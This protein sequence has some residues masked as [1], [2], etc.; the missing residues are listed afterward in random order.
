[1]F[2][3]E[4][5]LLDRIANSSSDLTI[6]A[7][8]ALVFAVVGGVIAYL[9]HK[10]WFRYW[11]TDSEYDDKL[12]E[13]AHTSMLGFAAFVLALL[14]SNGLSTLSETDKEVRAEATT[15]YRL[16]RELEAIGPEAGAA[17]EALAAYVK[18]V[19][20]DEWRRL[21]TLPVA[22]SPLAQ[23]NLDDLWI[24]LRALQAKEAEAAPSRSD[25]RADLSRHL[26]Q[27]ET[28]RS[29]RL[30]SATM[31]I[32]DD[33]WVILLLF[34]IAA[35]ILSGRRTAKRFGIQVNIMHMS[36]IGLAVGMVVVLDNP[37]RGE[38]SI[39]PEII[40]QAW[41][42]SPTRAEEGLSALQSPAAPVPGEAKAAPLPTK[43]AG[44]SRTG[45]NYGNR[46]R[47]SP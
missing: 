17:K 16:G 35:S 3:V 44:L 6:L 30:S 38:T 2:G 36:A 26:S 10:F 18:N 4:Q 33:F 21:A 47:R 28:L 14:I 39:G 22:L 1:M 12:A 46:G 37:F 29:G 40:E 42:P 20:Q 34:V 11:P 45:T 32:P 7:I 27:I 9:A 8:A 23:K 5:A 25:Y 15:I 24:A 13:A 19:A 43:P 41:V 31:N